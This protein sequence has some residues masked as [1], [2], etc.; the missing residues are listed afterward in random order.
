M[1]VYI[2]GKITGNENYKAQFESAA[3]QIEALGH[4]V[5]NP[6]LLPEGMT[7]EE[8]MRICTAMISVCDGIWVLPNYWNS[9]W[10]K[11]AISL[12]EYCDKPVKYLSG[13]DWFDYDEWR[14]EEWSV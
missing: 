11:I 5:L 13:E 8:Y 7:A 9:A 4:I 10:T 2:A 12:C 1:K 14:R 3:R 6:A